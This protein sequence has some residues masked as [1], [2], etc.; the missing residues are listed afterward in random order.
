MR[1]IVQR[2]LSASVTV[3]GAVVAQIGP[4]IMALV[5]ILDG[6]TAADVDHM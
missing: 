1:C 5:G 3:D 2:V 4:G 6:D